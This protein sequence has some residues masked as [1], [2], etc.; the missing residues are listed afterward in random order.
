MKVNYYTD[1]ISV[2]FQLQLVL[3]HLNHSLTGAN[4]TVYP[5]ISHLGFI[6]AFHQSRLSFMLSFLKYKH[7]QICK[8]G[9]DFQAQKNLIIASKHQLIYAGT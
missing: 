8:A 1:L 2:Y 7:T 9:R 3:L 4:V 5:L 6:P